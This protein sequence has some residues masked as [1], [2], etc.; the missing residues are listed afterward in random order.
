MFH[1]YCATATKYIRP[2]FDSSEWSWRL[3]ALVPAVMVSR[4]MHKG[5]IVRDP[6]DPD[7]QNLSL[8]SSP[9][10]LLFGPLFLTGIMVW[11]GTCHFS[12]W[13]GMD[14]ICIPSLIK[15]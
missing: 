4:M 10:D 9:S 14:H 11:L 12:K 3:N 8:S 5:V 15:S 7:V 1:S 2:Y 6:S 13:S